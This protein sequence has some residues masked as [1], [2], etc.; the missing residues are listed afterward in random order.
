[1]FFP[2][3]GVARFIT[4]QRQYLVALG[5]PAFGLARECTAASLRQCTVAVGA[6]LRFQFGLL[7]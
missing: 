5:V 3:V 2:I 7:L 6:G 4:S 1:M